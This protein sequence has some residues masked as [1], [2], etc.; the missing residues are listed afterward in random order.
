[1]LNVL[2]VEAAMEIVPRKISRHPS[3][4]RNAKRDGKNPEGVLLDRSLHH[5]AMLDL[6]EGKKRGRPDILHFCLLEA[7]GS[8]LNKAGRLRSF[9][10][11]LNGDFIDFA[12]ELRLPR[13]CNRFDSLMEQL[14]AEKRVPPGG[15]EKPLI[16]LV[17]KSLK[18]LRGEIRPS[19]TFALTSHGKAEKLDE[20]CRRLAAEENPL[21]FLGAYPHGAMR[22]ETLAEAD[23]AVSIHPEALEAWVVTSRLVYEYEKACGLE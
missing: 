11:T 18:D 6:P 16:T 17:R 3:V 5:R 8:P 7:L 15:E 9:A 23:E 13:D 4:T 19:R 21:V 2:F 14:F 12:P 22:E 20:L 10:H 1:M